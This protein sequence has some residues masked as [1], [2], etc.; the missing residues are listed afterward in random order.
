VSKHA[1]ER[2]RYLGEI[3]R[4]EKEPRVAEFPTVSAAHEPS[5]LRFDVLS[6]PRRL[7]LESAKGSE[8]ALRLEESLDGGRAERA[9]QLVLQI[10]NTNVKAQPF[11]VEAGEVGA[12]AGQLETAPED[13]L[14][15][16]VTETSQSRVRPA[17]AESGQELPYRLR[18]P[19]R[20]DRNALAVEIP[21][22]ARSEGLQRDL[23]ADSFDED[24]R[25]CVAHV[26]KRPSRR[27]LPP[28]QWFEPHAC[29]RGAASHVVTRSSKLIHSAYFRIATSWD[30]LTAI[31]TTS[32]V[33]R[34]EHW[35]NR[36]VTLLGSTLGLGSGP[37]R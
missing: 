1:V 33:G 28:R 30:G 14:L 8:V 25:T 35:A 31:R 3:E 13:F 34:T 26:R 24:N 12:E 7:L 32:K 18:T 4:L 15:A 21:T 9:Y 27:V 6:P 23:I 37:T 11:H 20:H 2:A 22:T 17:G 10:C 16:S 5:Q 29:P 19:D 36:E